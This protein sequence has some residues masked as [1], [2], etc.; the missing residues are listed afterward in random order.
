[1]NKYSRGKIYKIVDN[2]NDNIYI[3]STVEKYL[4]NRLSKHKY[5][6]KCRSILIIK[7]GDYDIKLIENYPCESKEELE[8]R[9]A[10]YIRN[11]TCVNKQIPGRT[12]KEYQKTNKEKISE[13]QKEY[14]ENNKEAIKEYKKNLYQYM[15]SWGGNPRYNN[16]TLLKIDPNLFQ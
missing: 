3:G 10:Y 11:T 6:K 8:S 16:N 15:N 4:T 2:T 5:N 14:K 9:E 1:M 12:Q 7:N 13:Y